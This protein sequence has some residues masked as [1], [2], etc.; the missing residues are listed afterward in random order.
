MTL[1]ETTCGYCGKTIEREE[2]RINESLKNGWKMYCSAECRLASKNKREEY[3][4]SNCGKTVIRTPSSVK[5]YSLSGN[6]FCSHSCAASYNNSHFRLEKNNPN[7][8]GYGGDYKKK[9]SSLY[10][11][12]CALCEESD[13]VCLQV[14]HID[15]NRLNNDPDNL[16]ILCSNHHFKVHNGEYHP[17]FLKSERNKFKIT[18]D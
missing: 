15:H 3:K 8:K 12:R 1:K 9:A 13:P 7:W 2:R 10:E 5:K 14:H 11:S 17:D 16:I 6:V 4:C 18:M